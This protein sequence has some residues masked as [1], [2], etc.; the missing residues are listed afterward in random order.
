MHFIVQARFMISI[1]SCNLIAVDST[2]Y[3]ILNI[4]HLTPHFFY[5]FVH[6]Y[7]IKPHKVRIVPA[8]NECD[9]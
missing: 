9:D 8:C 6:S 5:A 3:I 7:E 2:A 1:N 4:Q